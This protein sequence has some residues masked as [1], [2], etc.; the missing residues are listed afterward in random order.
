MN[1]LEEC[2]LK[3]KIN[4]ILNHSLENILDFLGFI[5]DLK[6]DF[7]RLNKMPRRNKKNK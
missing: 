7:D 2:D 6:D 3:D 1:S 5:Q 4:T